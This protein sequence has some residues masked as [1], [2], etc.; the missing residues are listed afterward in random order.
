MYIRR[1]VN[2]KMGQCVTLSVGNTNT[3]PVSEGGGGG[4]TNVTVGGG[5]EEEEEEDE[6]CLGSCLK[7]A[8]CALCL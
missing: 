1:T 5:E 7:V 8:G 3:G 2:N 6:N 4:G